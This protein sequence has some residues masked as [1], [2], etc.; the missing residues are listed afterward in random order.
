MKRIRA[1]CAI[2]SLSVLMLSCASLPTEFSLPPKVRIVTTSEGRYAELMSGLRIDSV[3]GATLSS[4]G[5]RVGDPLYVMTIEPVVLDGRTIIPA[6]T[7][8]NGAVSGITPPKYK[9]IKAKID[10][11]FNSIELQGRRYPFVSKTS[12]DKS[13]LAL[14][15]AKAAGE[16]AAKEGIKYMIPSAQW[17][18]LARDAKKGYDYCVSDK[19]CVLEKGTAFIVKLEQPVAVPLR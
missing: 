12:L 14:Q 4:T 10:I 2:V 15:G 6:G 11:T 16:W 7:R 18:F 3:L 5:S 19:E 9:F 1:C 13:A 8:I 17:V